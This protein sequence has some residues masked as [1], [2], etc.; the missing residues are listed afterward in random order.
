M[1][2]RFLL[3]L[4]PA[5]TGARFINTASLRSVLAGGECVIKFNLFRWRS[6]G[7]PTRGTAILIELL[8]FV[9]AT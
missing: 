8:S 6:P 9:A 2:I 5:R 3:G 1:Q 7:T 4:V